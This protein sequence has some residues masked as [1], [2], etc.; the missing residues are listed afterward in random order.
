MNII[1]HTHFSFVIINTEEESNA[2]KIE[3]EIVTT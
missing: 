1:S 2:E 3:P